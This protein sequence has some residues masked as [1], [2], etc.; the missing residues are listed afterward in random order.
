VRLDRSIEVFTIADP[1]EFEKDIGWI[2][3]SLFLTTQKSA[4]PSLRSTHPAIGDFFTLF[5][6]DSFGRFIDV[7]FDERPSAGIGVEVN[8]DNL[9]GVSGSRLTSLTREESP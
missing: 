7:D 1:F 3:S 6:T 9:L 2:L 8:T 5:A 4:R